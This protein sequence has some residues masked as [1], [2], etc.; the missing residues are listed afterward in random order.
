[1]PSVP[2]ISPPWAWGFC[3]AEWALLCAGGIL[4]LGQ[5]CR[6]GSAWIFLSHRALSSTGSPSRWLAQ[7]PWEEPLRAP[8]RWQPACT[9]PWANPS[10]MSCRNGYKTDH[11]SGETFG[12]MSKNQKWSYSLLVCVSLLPAMPVDSPRSP[13]WSFT[14]PSW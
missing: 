9:S 5:S 13:C 3:P 11:I 14:F 1:M 7:L 12:H 6:C 2:N 10:S 4:T 8:Q